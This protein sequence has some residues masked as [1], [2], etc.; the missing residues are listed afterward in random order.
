MMQNCHP[1]NLNGMEMTVI[2]AVVLG[3]AR[4]TGGIGTITGA[5]LGTALLTILSNSLILIGVPAYWQKVFIG[6]IIIIGT[7]VSAYQSGRA[8]GIK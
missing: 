3:G 5:M 4:V 7:G 8:G 2:A 1:T 6:A